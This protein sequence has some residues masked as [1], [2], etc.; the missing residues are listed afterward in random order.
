MKVLVLDVGGSNLK[1]RITGD[2]ERSKIRT[3]PTYTPE[4][5]MDD[6]ADEIDGEDFDAVT[7]GFPSP[8]VEGRIGSEPQNLG[9]G[10]MDF[11]FEK[12]FGGPV[13]LINDAAMQAV[14]CYEGGRMLFLSLGTGLGSAMIVDYHVVPLELCELRWSERKTLEDQVGKEALF[15]LG[16]DAWEEGVQATV[17]MLADAFVP[18]SIVVGGGAA[19]LLR[20]LPPG[21][22]R[23]HNDRALDGGELLWTDNRFRI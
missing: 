12:A 10:W 9:P 18:D 19:K 13:K 7:V 4:E 22:R 11:R 20:Y 3:G 5:M 14:G 21:V 1:F 8:V 15:A 17:A 6:L 23:G 2:W 16:R